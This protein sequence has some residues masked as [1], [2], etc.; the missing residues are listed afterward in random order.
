MKPT[1]VINLEMNHA[2]D[3]GKTFRVLTTKD[4][5]RHY[6]GDLLEQSEVERLV[7]QKAITVN[8]KEVKS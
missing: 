8:I 3:G 1:P 4:T 5:V 7:Q 2:I 6:P